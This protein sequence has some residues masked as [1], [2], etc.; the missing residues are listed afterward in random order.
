[1]ARVDYNGLYYQYGRYILIDHGNGLSTLYA[2]LSGT[3]AKTGDSVEKGDLIG[4]VGST[5]FATGPHLHL[6]LYA[7]P[8][9][10]WR[11]STNREQGGLFSVPPASGLVP[12]GVTLNP[13]QYL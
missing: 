11:S 4:Y 8:S 7:T 6:G 2:H 13:A 1:M 12:I 5:G 3:T 9:A 10:G